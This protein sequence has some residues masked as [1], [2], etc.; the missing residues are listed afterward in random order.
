MGAIMMI[1]AGLTTVFLELP[2]FGFFYLGVGVAVYT[3]SKKDLNNEDFTENLIVLFRN[4]VLACAVCWLFDLRD[5]AESVHGL[6]FK[7]APY[8]AVAVISFLSSLF[9]LLAPVFI[10]VFYCVALDWAYDWD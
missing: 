7:Y 1:L 3:I 5:F 4:F 8:I 2:S 6:N 10:V 9:M